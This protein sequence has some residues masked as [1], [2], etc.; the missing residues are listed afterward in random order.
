M[1]VAIANCQGFVHVV[2]SGGAGGG[3]G[4]GFYAVS[5]DIPSS[6]GAHVL[7][8]GVSL[9]LSEIAQPSVTL[10]DRKNIYAFGSAWDEMALEGVMLLGSN[11]TGGR[12]LEVLR[13]WYENNRLSVKMGPVQ[14]SLGPGAVDAYVIGL[15]LGPANPQFNSQNFAV[16]MLTTA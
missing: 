13:G 1:S 5:P 11:S 6:G 16:T 10:D 3:G 15:R 8:Q 7:I 9:N 12:Q 2:P 4:G 14:V